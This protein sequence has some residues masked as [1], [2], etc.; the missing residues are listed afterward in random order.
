MNVPAKSVTL[1][2]GALPQASKESLAAVSSEISNAFTAVEVEIKFKTQTKTSAQERATKD[3]IVSKRTATTL[4]AEAEPALPGLTGWWHASDLHGAAGSNI[5]S[6]PNR[7][8]GGPAAEHPGSG[9]CAS[10]GIAVPPVVSTAG[11]VFK[12]PGGYLCAALPATGPKS[13]VAAFTA[14]SDAMLWGA[15]LAGYSLTT[16]VFSIETMWKLPLVFEIPLDN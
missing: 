1:T 6:W 12:K 3:Q 15:L 4:V 11:A 5:T 9:S 10:V 7:V 14:S 16:F 13:F 8:S 2:F